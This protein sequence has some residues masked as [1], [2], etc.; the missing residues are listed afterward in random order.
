MGK[1]KDGEEFDHEQE[2]QH[3]LAL[4]QAAAR[5]GCFFYV[6]DTA[7]SRVQVLDS[8]G[9]FVTTFGSLGDGNDQFN[10][11]GGICL[12][13]SARH[14]AVADSR[15]NRVQ[16]FDLEFNYLYTIGR[17]NQ[18]RAPNG[19]GCDAAGN[20]A[21]A[22]YGN[23]RVQICDAKG[24]VVRTIG[25]YGS[26]VNDFNR[27]FDVY[28]DRHNRLMVCDGA[29]SRVSIWSRDGGQ[30]Q[31]FIS[32]LLLPCSVGEDWNETLHV[33][34]TNTSRS[35][36][37]SALEIFDVRKDQQHLQTVGRAGKRAGEF[38]EIHGMCFDDHNMMYLTDGCN[39]RIQVLENANAPK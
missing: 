22:D 9:Q 1:D 18:L 35:Y 31:G 39:D 11:P 5:T 2:H 10:T 30:P 14:V 38:D 16:V 25:G 21:I 6:V 34:C 27:P 3:S 17:R 4:H 8:G 7:N 24:R 36:P 33:G 13:L 26:S 15:N 28:Y 12:Q 32:T 37:Q 23:N 29:N 19:I 20:W